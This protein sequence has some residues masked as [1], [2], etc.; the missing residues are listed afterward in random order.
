M[1]STPDSQQLRAENEL[2]LVRLLDLDALITAREGELELLRKMAEEGRRLKSNMDVRE[3]ETERL[4][5]ELEAAQKKAEGTESRRQDLENEL[6]ESMQNEK[7]Y[8][9]LNGKAHS[10][11]AEIEV[12]LG[13]LSEATAFNQKI[14]ELES[15]LVELS[16]RLEIA[17]LDRD[18]LKQELEELRRSGASLTA[19][20]AG[21]DATE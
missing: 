17:E 12:L 1:I 15:R 6:L 5:Q 2:L 13:E 7:K 21:D 9:E 14:R 3:V 10:M 20:M 8:F 19:K 11:Q 16:S 18:M 4:R